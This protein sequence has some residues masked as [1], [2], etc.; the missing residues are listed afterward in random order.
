MHPPMT[1][2]DVT[3]TYYDV[4]VNPFTGHGG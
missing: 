3:M 2:C 1:C 4:I